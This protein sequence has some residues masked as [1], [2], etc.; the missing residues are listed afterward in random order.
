MFE[1]PRS[2]CWAIRW[3]SLTSPASLH[4]GHLERIRRRHICIRWNSIRGVSSR[5]IRREQFRSFSPVSLESWVRL[6]KIRRSADIALRACRAATVSYQFRPTSLRTWVQFFC[7]RYG[8]GHPLLAEPG[9]GKLGGL[10]LHPAPLNFYTV[11]DQTWRRSPAA[12]APECETR[13]ICRYIPVWSHPNGPSSSGSDD[14]RAS[15]G[16]WRLRRPLNDLLAGLWS[17]D[18]FCAS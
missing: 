5:P 12:E 9:A 8:R 14:S 16:G 17:T 13:S 10:M 15:P 18:Q 4:F 11:Q 3:E 2:R 1:P 6:R 7:S